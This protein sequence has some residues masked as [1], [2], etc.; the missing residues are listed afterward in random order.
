MRIM[1][2]HILISLLFILF[3]YSLLNAQ[4]QIDDPNFEQALID[5]GIDK[6]ID[7]FV[8]TDSIKD[9][10]YLEISKK[11]ISNLEGIGGFLSLETLICDNNELI[12]INVSANSNLKIL[13]CGFNNLQTLDVLSNNAL[14]V[15]DC[16]G[17]QISTLNTANNGLLEKLTCSDNR[18]NT[19]DITQN[20]KLKALTISNNQLND[21]DVTKNLNLESLFCASN[22]ISNLD[23]SKNGLLK[24]L[25]VS[26]N[27]IKIL[28]LTDVNVVNCPDPQTNPL[29]PC[30]GLGSI[31]VSNNQLTSLIVANDF[32]DLITTFNSEGNPEL[33]CIQ[34]DNGFMAS[35]YWQK[36]DWTYYSDTACTDI[37]TYVP[38]DAFEAYLESN[39]MGNNLGDGVLNNNFVLTANINTLTDLD[40]SDKSIEDL[41]GI[42]DFIALEKLNCSS[43]DIKTIDLSN[44][45][46]LAQLNCSVNILPN[47]RL[48]ANVLLE[49]LDCSSQKPYVDQ[50]DA[51]KNYT[52]SGLKVNANVELVTID[53]SNNTLKGLD[54]SDN[55]ALENL[56]CSFNQLSQLDLSSNLDLLTLDTSDNNLLAL[57]IKN[58][59]IADLT[60][61]NAS[62]NTDLY[63]I[64]VDNKDDADAKP[65]TNWIK[66]IQASYELNCGTYVP[67]NAF[68]TYLEGEGLGD[69]EMNN[70]VDTSK[71]STE[72]ILDISVKGIQDL[73]GIEDF[74]ALQ[75]LNCSSNAISNLDLSN[76]IE[77]AVIDCSLNQIDNLDFRLNLKLTSLICNSN[78]LQRLDVRNGNNNN[79]LNIFNATK[80]PSLFCIN[81]DDVN[82]SKSAAGWLEDNPGFYNTDCDNSR[83]TD[84]PDNN[85]EQ[86][87]VDLGIDKVPNDN[88]VLTS[89][90]EHLLTLNVN[91][92]QIESLMGIKGFASLKELDCSSNYLSD[93]DVSDM[94]NLEVLYCS[95]NYFLTNTDIPAANGLLK[96]NGTTELRILFCSNNNLKDLDVSGFGNLEVLNCSNNSIGDLDISNNLKLKEIYCNSNKLKNL[97]TAIVNNTSLKKIY[98]DNNQLSSLLIDNNYTSLT[99]LS[100]TSNKL[101]Q[102]D[103]ASNTFL[104]T[105]N[106]SSNDMSSVGLTTN[107]N[108]LS[109]LCSQNQLTQLSLAANTLLETINC[110]NNQINDLTVNTIIN[111]KYLYSNTNQLIGLDLLSNNKLIELDVN[112]N[113]LTT[114]DLSEDLS[115]LKTFDCSRNNLS[116]DL[117]LSSIGTV[118]CPPPPINPNDTEYYCPETISINV[119]RNA[120]S[121]LNIQNGI[122]GEISGFNATNN[123]D[124]DC[125]QVD[126]VNNIGENWL[127]DVIATYSQDCRF[128]ETYVP[129]EAFEQALRDLGYDT[130]TT[131]P[132]DNYVPTALIEGLPNLDV[133]GK[134]ISDLTGLKDFTA[135]QNLNCS[136]NALNIIDLK[137]N[138]N[139]AEIN[140]SNNTFSDLDFSSNSALITIDCS[141]N[142]LSSLYLSANTN[143]TNLNISY[144]SFST[145]LPSAIP[146][147]EDFNCDSNQLSDLDLSTNSA[148]TALSCESNTLQTLNI[149]NGQNAS[150]SNLNAQSNTALTCIVT[151]LGNAPGGV[152]WF[153]DTTAEYEIDCHYG[154]TY[155][156]DDGFE[157]ALI[158][159][160]LDSGGLD[161]YVLTANID[162]ISNLDISNNTIG[163]LT[164]LEDFIDLKKLNFSDNDVVDV[165][166]SK[167]VLLEELD[168]S[169]NG[170]IEI[171]FSLNP[172]LEVLNISG[173]SLS[174]V[175]LNANTNLLE[176]NVSGNQLTVLNA[177]TLVNLQFLDCSS[178]RLESLSVEL[179]PQLVNLYCQSNSF[180]SDQLNLQ[181]GANP[182]LINFNA[183]DNVGLQCILVDDP[184]TVITN[185]GGV[186]DN[187]LKDSGSNYQSVC[188]DADNDGIANADDQCPNTPFGSAVDLFGCPILSLPNN[189]FTIQITSE[190][191]LNN[192]NG[193][194]NIAT[195]DY[196]NY[197]ATLTKDNFSK[198]YK[199][200]NDIDILNLLAGTYKMCISIEEWP[201]YMNCYDVVISQ[202]EPLSVSTNKST[203]GKKV[204]VK[205]SGS[206]SYNVDFNGLTFSTNDSN[207]TLNLQEGANA[208]KVSTDIECQGVHEERILVS[209]KMIVYP[210]P[211]QDK[212]NMYLG[213]NDTGKVVVNMYSYLGQLVYSKTL[214]NQKS[215]K[216]SLDTNNLALGIY[217]ISIQTST[218]LSTFKI[219]KK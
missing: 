112:S 30:Q 37:Y 120:L 125:I 82:Y 13:L 63:C 61:F 194:I 121:S 78:S 64:E 159:K 39:P 134:G 58:V 108:L 191:C 25:D 170:I 100:C 146:S 110:N 2:K 150:L 3:V 22:S 148:L 192:N 49:T 56:D 71:I 181:N 9:V 72:T 189:N 207:I 38:D 198:A 70:F 149:K 106:F 166:L 124:L 209:D 118:A 113:L 205:M 91:G 20:D 16:T 213:D 172:N 216:I 14:E 42:E 119:S 12:S 210:N 4:T 195:L 133:S 29:T 116:I 95:S 54:V 122:N 184:F 32:N 203:D 73:T 130:N 27:L 219:I 67:D 97:T 123:S 190:T 50:D 214:T 94:I 144:N 201:N 196:Y 76:N 111:L 177:D 105:L 132:L 114:L 128:G 99:D 107:T 28:D 161:N 162:N 153:K 208:I 193:K 41:T 103:L 183:T 104:E 48:T 87:L 85:F 47:L 75:N 43:N 81:V 129:D 139:L 142:A 174:E 211:F 89:N 127:K 131:D 167:N 44:N 217:T 80:N 163:D 1:K 152:T 10:T 8:E 93:L 19:I 84:I 55:I 62:N 182:S 171:D 45:L 115:Q 18:L 173:N 126:D 79:Q 69:G 200:T 147:L 158:I 15:L 24:N 218:S 51:T 65:T 160:G 26:N 59:I 60:D 186:Y 109:L 138:L 40:I 154:E 98:C 7:G 34:V 176:L 140:C 46:S 212:I 151:D 117:D 180:V 17:N 206:S 215:G 168:V 102:I 179:N 53:C 35:D 52:F 178:N 165:D 92:K 96:T 202:P 136:N 21:L 33:F 137:K 74:T 199:F 88:R 164:G 83:F 143:L 5:L 188:I 68:E 156:P 6:E 101:T 31:N 57:S 197:T 169:N 11:N 155:V 187:W 175:D 86:A 66:D 23:L 145:F 36:D 135:L 141:S 77:L 157:Q 204:S 185:A 90:I